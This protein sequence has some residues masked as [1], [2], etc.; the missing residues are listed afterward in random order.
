MLT[1]VLVVLYACSWKYLGFD[2]HF[3]ILQRSRN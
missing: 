3:S 1:F 2:L